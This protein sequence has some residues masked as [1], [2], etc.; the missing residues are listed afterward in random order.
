MDTYEPTVFRPDDARYHGGERSTAVDMLVW[1]QSDGKSLR[2]AR[3]WLNRASAGIHKA[4]YHYMIDYDGTIVRT[5]RP[6]LVAYHAGRS[7]HPVGRSGVLPGQSVN[8]RSIG[9]CF[10]GLIS[11]AR[12]DE[13]TRAGLW[14]GRVLWSRFHTKFDLGHKEVAP[15]RKFDPGWSMDEW[16]KL[17]AEARGA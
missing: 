10:I 5:L 8:K 11:E 15:G 1:H 14:L 17:L 12:T 7:A 16:R 3:E 9:I 4:S 6:E 13:Q 2:G